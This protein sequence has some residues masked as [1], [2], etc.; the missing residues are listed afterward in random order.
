MIEAMT[1]AKASGISVVI[2]VVLVTVVILSYPVAH[3]DERYAITEPAQT[4]LIGGIGKLHHAIRTRN[5]EAQAFFDE[6]LTLIYGFD[7]ERAVACFRR[8]SELD[9]GS[10]MPYWGI[11]LALG[12]NYN[13]RP[14]FARQRIAYAAIAEARSRSA[15]GSERDRAYI[16][17]LS[18]RYTTDSTVSLNMLAR[19]YAF[20]MRDVWR[21]F[22]DDP[23]AAALYAESLMDL[24]PWRLWNNDG[25]PGE[26]TLLIV[27]VL[28][29]TLK[30]WPDH[31]GANH[32]YIHALEGSPF[33]ERAMSSARLLETLVP[34]CSHLVHMPAHIYFR[35]GDY[36]AAVRVSLRAIESDGHSLQGSYENGSTE[37]QAR[38]QGS[39]TGYAQHN[40][41][42]LT[43]AA[44]MDGDYGE[45][46]KS[47]MRTAA[48]SN[49]ELY[50]ISPVLVFARFGRW[51]DVLRVEPPAEQMPGAELFW[52]YARGCAYAETNNLE[53]A[54][55]E[56]AGMVEAYHR[57][58]PGPAFGALVNDWS[59][60]NTIA[61]DVLDARIASAKRDTEGSLQYW[62]R[63]VAVQ[64]QLAFDD[65]PD[66]YYPTRE[67]LGAALLRVGRFVQAEEV[68]HE[69]LRRTRLNP[70]SLYGLWQSLVAQGKSK[71]ASP[72]HDSFV[73]RWRGTALHVSLL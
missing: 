53:G 65:L 55:R 14:S 42:F 47:A 31:V 32:F 25:Q 37:P 34:A 6:G 4:T 43:A 5:S 44:M 64:D 66:W 16:G 58:P 52:H 60:L 22:P 20:A 45:A 3:S 36:I 26:Y 63:A 29:S 11:A 1:K 62:R 61:L 41:F 56:R 68:F 24:H 57:I 70:R 12:P 54:A 28:E 23:D 7:V 19:N 50:T 21:R 13:F 10:P 17:A 30:R 72:V 71:E 73:E 40:M 49:F 59:T 8:V 9:P 33:P 38:P 51:R 2:A 18:Q 35:T 27:Q 48:D 15:A 69:D 46:H 39:Y 67:S